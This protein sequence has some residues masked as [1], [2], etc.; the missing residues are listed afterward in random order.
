MM[1]RVF[2]RTALK[3][4]DT[5][6]LLGNRVLAEIVRDPTYPSM[7]RFRLLPDGELFDM[8]NLTRAKDAAATHVLAVLNGKETV[9]GGAV[10]RSGVGV[11]S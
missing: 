9:Q 10:V 1:A 4:H 3:W 6:L 7:W 8:V 5:R 2:N 11:A